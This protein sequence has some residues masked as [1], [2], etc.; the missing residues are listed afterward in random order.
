MSKPTA[1]FVAET[2]SL[3]WKIN[4]NLALQEGETS[5][6]LARC[7]IEGGQTV[8]SAVHLKWKVVGRTVSDLGVTSVGEE[9]A[10]IEEVVRQCVAGKFIASP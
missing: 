2:K 5:K 1:T 9:G 3:F 4:D 7:Q 6:L 10:R 8:P